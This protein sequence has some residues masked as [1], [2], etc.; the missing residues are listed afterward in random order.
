MLAVA[1]GWH[2]YALTGSPFYL[3]L[4]GLAQFLPMFVLTLIA[5]HAADRY[6]RRL[7]IRACQFIEGAGAAVLAA[8]SVSGRLSAEAILGVVFV[9]GA[10]RAFEYP[11][12]QALLP[13]LVSIDLFPR[14]VAWSSS[15][16]QTAV[17]VGPALGGLL[18][19]LDPGV[20]YFAIGL[21]F[22]SAGL[23]VSLIRIERRRGEPGSADLRSLFAG[24]AFIRANPPIL[25]AISL[26]LFAVLLG[27]A[28]ALLPV[29]AR[30]ILA[31]G[32]WG[33]GLLRSAPA[34]GAL[35]MSIGLA[36]RPLRGRVGRTM[37]VAV[38]IFGIATISF[39]LSTSL[40]PSL[41][42]LAVLGA[43]DVFSV[44]IRQSLV[45]MNTPDAMRGRVSAVNS[46]FIGTS[47]Q[48][49]EFESGLTAA[50]FGVVPAVVI[51]GAGTILVALI[52]MRL[53]PQL[54]RVDTPEG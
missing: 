16:V 17:I 24:I 41:L 19:A 45:Q 21:L 23:L 1:V 14:A 47:N 25:G 30:D 5:G 26:D 27:G 36:R 8:G 7:I 11:T 35:T 51:G 48:L 31:V 33:L 34:F 3:G 49:G 53:F 42:S 4:V 38:I 43:A 54:L 52:W 29:Y 13:N 37:F 2:I 18:Y 39:G 50:W 20:A 6:D 32:P 22:A 46:M 9:V 44:V 40:L 10:A 12:M 15:S 28:T